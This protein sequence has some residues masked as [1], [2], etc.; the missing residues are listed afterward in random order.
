[1]LHVVWQVV[2]LVRDN[3]LE[4][5]LV[6][7]DL[8]R[9]PVQPLVLGVALPAVI[10]VLVAVLASSLLDRDG[11]GR[12]MEKSLALRL[13]TKEVFEER[14]CL[15]PSWTSTTVKYFLTDLTSLPNEGFISLSTLELLPTLKA[16]NRWQ[17]PRAARPLR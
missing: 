14:S 1:M 17:A 7:H 13:S 8:V 12:G 10:V 6:L 5:W 3:L 2:E 15:R 4:P 11:T 9:V 16:M